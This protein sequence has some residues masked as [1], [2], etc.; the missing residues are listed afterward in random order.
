MTAKEKLIIRLNDAVSKEQWGRV[1]RLATALDDL[2]PADHI[3][4][5]YENDPYGIGEERKRHP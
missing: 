4:A 5:M 3:D 1:I 2:V